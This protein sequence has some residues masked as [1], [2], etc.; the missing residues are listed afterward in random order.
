MFWKKENQKRDRHSRMDQKT[1]FRW[2]LSYLPVLLIPLALGGILYGYSMNAVQEKAETIQYTMLEDRADALTEVFDTVGNVTVM[3]QGNQDVNKLANADKWGAEERY[4]LGEVQKL[5]AEYTLNNEEIDDIYL[6][7]PSRE[8]ILGTASA[9]SSQSE[10]LLESRLGVSQDEMYKLLSADLYRSFHIVEEKRL[11]YTS[12]YKKNIHFLKQPVI[13]MVYL[14]D[15]HLDYLLH[16][17]EV[18]FFFD[19][20]DRTSL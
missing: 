14:S 11:L 16:T 9:F 13:V 8:T 6:Y 19:G 12:V 7:F 5:L 10:M 17:S 20:S 18:D 15:E 1:I 2:M 3:I 4:R